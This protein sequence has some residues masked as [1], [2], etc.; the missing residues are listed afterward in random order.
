[1]MNLDVHIETSTLEDGTVV[2]AVEG[3]LDLFVAPAFK[4]ELL[5]AI[6]AAGNSVVVDLT[7]CG[8]LDSSA[9][10][11]LVHARNDLD[12]GTP[13]FSL[14]I[15]EPNVLRIFEI[16]HL[17][18]LFTIYP[19]R[20]TALDGHTRAA[21]GSADGNGRGP[22]GASDPSG[23]PR[24]TAGA[25]NDGSSTLPDLEPNKPATRPT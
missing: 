18:H 9:L 24:M 14:V 12:G 19:D 21:D 15:S 16:S 13:S 23:F 8:F 11:A 4:D 10:N 20:T 6:R 1:M 2:V 5:N 17:D 25:P 3:E 7:L 22:N